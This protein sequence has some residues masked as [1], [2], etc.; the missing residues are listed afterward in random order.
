MTSVK[1]I[2]HVNRDQLMTALRVHY[3][4]DEPLGIFG[5]PGVGKSTIITK[6]FR[7]KGVAVLDIRPMGITPEDIMGHGVIAN[8]DSESPKVV[9]A[10]PDIVTALEAEKQ[11]LGTDKGM[12]FIDEIDK[13]PPVVQGALLQVVLDRRAGFYDLPENTYVACG[14][15]SADDGSFSEPLSRALVNRMSKLTYAGPTLEEFSEYMVEKSFH[16]I[17]QAFLRTQPQYVTDKFNPQEEQSP[18]PRGWQ[19][20]SNLLKHAPKSSRLKMLAGRVGSE[21]AHHLE[22]TLKVYDSLVP[23]SEIVADPTSARLPDESDVAAQYM[24]TL[25]VANHV[26]S[27]SQE[28]ITK[29]A[30]VAWTY[31]KRMETV[32]GSLFLASLVPGGVLSRAFS[33]FSDELTNKDSRYHSIVN[34]L[35]SVGAK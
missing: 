35:S 22:A 28:D 8:A 16:P 17:V 9:R 21:A 31:M 23:I 12:I 24:Q 30:Q 15:N 11:K 26:S 3:E 7:D 6:F 10:V 34:Q 14:G 4:C 19:A 33:V 2:D 29:A 13:A 20:A 32:Q 25:A 1:S 5:P 27:D 18:T